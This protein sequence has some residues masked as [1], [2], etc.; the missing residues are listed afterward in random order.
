MPQSSLSPSSLRLAMENRCR[1]SS[2]FGDLRS[3]ELNGLRVRKRS[4]LGDL[5][6]DASGAGAGV[7]AIEHDGEPSPP[8]AVSFCKVGVVEIPTSLRCLMKK[9]TSASMTRAAACRPIHLAGKEQDKLGFAIGLHIAM[10][11]LTYAGTRYISLTFGPSASIICSLISVNYFEEFMQVISMYLLQEDNQILTASGDQHIKIWNAEKRTCTGSLAGHTGSVK[12]V[13]SHSSNPDLVVSGSRDG[14]FALWDLRCSFSS[15]NR[16]GETCLSPISLVNDA[17]ALTQRKRGWRG[18]ADSKSITSVLYLKDG[19]SIATAGA[20]NSVVKFWDTRNLKTS[21]IQTCPAA[22]PSTKSS[23]ISLDGAHILGGSSDD[24]AYIWQVRRPESAPTILKGHQGEVT[25]VDW[26]SS[27]LGKVVTSS[28]D[29]MVR[30]WKMNK[31]G[32]LNT[33]SPAAIR[34][35]IIA[36]S[37]E[38]RRLILDEPPTCS[39]SM[40]DNFQTMEATVHEPSSPA[41]CKVV[42]F[43]TP[44]SGRKRSSSFLMDGKEM[45]ESLEAI[46]GSPS[47]VLSPPPSTKR[48]TILDYYHSV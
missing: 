2:F 4:H 20:V 31:D 15:T 8:T 3:R 25:S 29:F 13:C 17:H 27:E 7:L 42:E 26:C 14:S 30:V 5:T 41:Q 19:I 10:L 48:R 21:I 34:K 43:R 38:P 45:Q 18:K 46:S 12:T 44:E 6:S 9:D 11:Y 32:C 24:N 22:E 40:K 1:P 37:V 28:D 36:P 47:S 39:A 16:F 33:K 23:V 35:R